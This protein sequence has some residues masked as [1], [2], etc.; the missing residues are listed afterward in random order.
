MRTTPDKLLRAVTF[1]LSA[2]VGGGERKLRE[3]QKELSAAAVNGQ[4]TIICAPTGTS[5]D[6]TT[7]Q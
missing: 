1:D 5:H 3:Y 4:N 6:T 2:G 7:H